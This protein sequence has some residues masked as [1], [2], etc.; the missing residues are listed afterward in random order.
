AR[1]E[2]PP[3]RRRKGDVALLARHFARLLGGEDAAI[4]DALLARWE[5][6]PWPGNV[7]ELR[8]AIARHLALGELAMLGPPPDDDGADSGEALP[9]AGVHSVAVPLAMELPLAEARQRAIDQFDRSYVKRVLAHHG[10]NV[11]R[12]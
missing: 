10:G 11:T 12:A 7:R 9:S 4:G 3:L 2:L 1:V 6:L 5:D 8:N